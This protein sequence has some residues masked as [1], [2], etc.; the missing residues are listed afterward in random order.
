MPFPKK[1]TFFPLQCIHCHCATGPVFS[2]KPPPPTPLPEVTEKTPPGGEICAKTPPLKLSPFQ[3]LAF[4]AHS[5]AALTAL[6]PAL[7]SSDT[8]NVNGHTAISCSLSLLKIT[9]FLQG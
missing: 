6:P 3:L 8:V 9:T 2:G 7:L 5:V 1:G 4:L